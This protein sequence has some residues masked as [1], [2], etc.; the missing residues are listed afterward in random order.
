MAK[1]MKAGP[2]RRSLRW[3]TSSGKRKAFTVGGVLAALTAGGVAMA[4]ILA[5]ITGHGTGSRLDGQMEVLDAIAFRSDQVN[6]S[7]D[8]ANNPWLPATGEDLAPYTVSLAQDEASPTVW[9]VD[10]S[11][12]VEGGVYPIHIQAAATGTDLRLAEF[13]VENPV[14]ATVS[15]YTPD[16]NSR[17][18]PITNGTFTEG[19]ACQKVFTDGAPAQFVPILVQLDSI[20]A[21]NFSFDIVHKFEADTGVPNAGCQLQEVNPETMS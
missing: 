2:V 8:A 11:G 10:I 16:L 19:S 7:W 3:M 1:H 20:T 13:V 12:A 4:L 17:S 14:G 9:S 6:A 5:T 21:A 15:L 18:N